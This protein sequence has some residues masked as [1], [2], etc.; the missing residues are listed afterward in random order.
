MQFKLI[1]IKTAFDLMDQKCF[2]LTTDPLHWHGEVQ[3]ID[4]WYLIWKLSSSNY[5]D[6]DRVESECCDG[7]MVENNSFVQFYA[8]IM[9][10]A[11]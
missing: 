8:W 9:I 6:H 2:S 10:Y 1:I 3:F 5:S 11:I 7:C 4:A